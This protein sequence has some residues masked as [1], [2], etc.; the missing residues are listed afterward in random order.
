MLSSMDYISITAF[1]LVLVCAC[2][3]VTIQL[4]AFSMEKILIW[5]EKLIEKSLSDPSK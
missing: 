3:Q 1:I 4:A 2:F 5:R